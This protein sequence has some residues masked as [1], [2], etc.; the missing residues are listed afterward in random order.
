VFPLYA[1]LN[2]LLPK[3]AK[4]EELVKEILGTKPIVVLT[5]PVGVALQYA[6]ETLVS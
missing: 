6:S 4:T 2:V 3:Q 1:K 5:L